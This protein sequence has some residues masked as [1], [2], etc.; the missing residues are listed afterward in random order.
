MKFTTQNNNKIAIEK[1]QFYSIIGIFIAILLILCAESFINLFQTN[2]FDD[3]FST[4][5]AGTDKIQAEIAFRRNLI[6][7]LLV[8]SIVYIAIAIFWYIAYAKTGIGYIFN[9]IMVLVFVGQILSVWLINGSSLWSKI[10]LTIISI[11]GIA[12]CFYLF[13]LI[14]QHIFYIKNNKRWV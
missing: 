2:K 5:P 13:V 14:K 11:L 10:S 1:W 6:I 3:Y 7:H 12:L 9:F 8:N 4:L